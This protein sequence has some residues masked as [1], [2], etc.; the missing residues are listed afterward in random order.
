MAIPA[1]FTVRMHAMRVLQDKFPQIVDAL[2]PGGSG[3]IMPG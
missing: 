3:N 2:E 1:V